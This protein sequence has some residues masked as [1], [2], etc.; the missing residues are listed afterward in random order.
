MRPHLLIPHGFEANYTVGFARGLKANDVA[1]VV[2]SDNDI[3]AR[4]DGAGIPHRNI[5][6]SVDPRR[7]RLSKIVNFV[8]YYLALLTATIRHRGRTQ[9]FTGLLLS[10]F[11][12]WEGLLL[13]VWLRIWA[14]R[15]VHT[16][17]NV[18]PHGR[19]RQRRFR[20]AYRWIYRFPHHIVAHCQAT[21]DQLQRDF[22]VPADRITVI[23]IGLNEE[24][25]Q[26]DLTPAQAKAELGL[27][28]ER[29]MLFFGKVEPYKGVDRLVEAWPQVSA[30]SQLAIAG[31]SIDPAYG[32]QVRAAILSSA[33]PI[34][35]EEGHVPNERAALWLTAADALVLPYRHIYQSGLVF[36]SQRFGLPVIATDV[37]SMREYVD[38]D[39]GL[40]AEDNS[41][42]GLA[43]AIN[44]FLADP[45]RFS[46]G[47]IMRRAAKFSWSA[48]CALI[49]LLYLP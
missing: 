43:T 39:S 28:S 47:E 11:I 32:S 29:L 10:R 25:P 33:R 38:A 48:Q 20:W 6:G 5:R 22:G 4:L 34:R 30:P 1:F 15:Y 7:G 41:A 8:R 42:E 13:P 31:L 12:W 46:R 16:A 18:L 9:H 40:I 19:E 44:R 27:G 3:A 35:W 45:D 2:L 17:H 26:P 23:S 14:G 21:S 37:G 36:L 49:R 24:M